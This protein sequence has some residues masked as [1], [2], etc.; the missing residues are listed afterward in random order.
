V[1]EQQIIDFSVNPIPH[2]VK[3]IG[4]NLSL[5][6]FNDQERLIQT[7]TELPPDKPIQIGATLIPG[8]YFLKA[9]QSGN[10]KTIKLIKL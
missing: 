7:L 8:V 6:L 5:Q 10:I 2:F 3:A 4:G 1:S 9:I